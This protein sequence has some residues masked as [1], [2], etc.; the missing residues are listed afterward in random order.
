[1]IMNVSK[2]KAMLLVLVVFVLGAIV[3]GSLSTTLISQRLDH[4]GPG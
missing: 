4:R 1:M 2:L 3:G